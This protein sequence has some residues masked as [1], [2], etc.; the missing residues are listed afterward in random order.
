MLPGQYIPTNYLPVLITI[1]AATLFGLGALIVGEFLRL[2]RPY[3]DKLDPYES[4]NPPVGQPG[5]RFSIRFY[6]IAVLFVV[7]DVEAVFLYPWAVAFGQIGIIG[8]WAMVVFLLLIFLGF[9][10]DWKKGALE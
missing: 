10:Y 5:E 4:G 7:F 9:L 6:V 2:R 3:K 8:F 1:I